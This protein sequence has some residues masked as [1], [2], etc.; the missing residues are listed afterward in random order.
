[1]KDP[2]SLSEPWRHVTHGERA[3]H[4]VYTYN[5]ALDGSGVSHAPE[6]HMVSAR[7]TYVT[8]WPFEPLLAPLSIAVMHET[9][10]VSLRSVYHGR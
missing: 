6:Q 7:L 10:T 2:S 5:Q 8:E 1:M 3:A 4:R 9:R